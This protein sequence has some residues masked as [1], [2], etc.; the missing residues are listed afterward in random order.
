MLTHELPSECGTGTC[1][2]DK[3]LITPPP[4]LHP[5]WPSQRA[6]C[7]STPSADF[8][9]QSEM[10]TA[11]SLQL[12]HLTLPPSPHTKSFLALGLSMGSPPVWAVNERRDPA[13]PCTSGREH[14]T[15]LSDQLLGLGVQHS[16]VI[17]WTNEYTGWRP[18]RVNHSMLSALL[19]V[20]DVF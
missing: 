16:S 3:E 6:N 14:F 19:T 5:F 15:L 13:D 8:D 7:L 12:Q 18:N 17:V 4:E 9:R 10:R 2:F 1:P 11:I 20:I